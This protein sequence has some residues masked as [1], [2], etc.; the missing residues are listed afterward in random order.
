MSDVTTSESCRLE[1]LTFELVVT[2]EL[3]IPDEVT[4]EYNDIDEFIDQ[5]YVKFE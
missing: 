4:L 2:F 3:V 1:L 5:L